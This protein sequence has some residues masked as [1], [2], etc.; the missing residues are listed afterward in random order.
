MT[1]FVLELLK[2]TDDQI[3]E[4]VALL[5]RA[6]EGDISVDSMTGGND[7]LRAPL[8]RS[9]VRA[10]ALE[11]SFYIANDGSEK[12]F[13]IGI[14]FGPGKMMFGTEA[15]RKEGW[16]DLFT[17]FSP[18]TQKWW[19]TVF[20]EKH[21]QSLNRLLGDKYL[22]S[23]FSNIIATDPEH[24][25]KGYATAITKVVFERAASENKPVALATHTEHNK[26]WYERM[27]FK[28]LGQVEIP[29]ETGHWPD[30]FLL[31]EGPEIS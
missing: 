15:Q 3:E 14:W 23:W 28:T 24:Q 27:G 18:E 2:A 19:M 6:F 4:A 12:I 25:R 29:S 21:D 31:W 9:M 13:S 26:A 16:D 17:A 30:F 22:N 7:E 1:I 11:G 8:F 10:G 5:M 20:H